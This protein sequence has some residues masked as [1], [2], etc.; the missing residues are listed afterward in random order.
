MGRPGPSFPSLTPSTPPPR[1]PV[2]LP[3]P[4]LG[5]QTPNLPNLSDVII[6]PPTWAPGLPPALPVLSFRP[7]ASSQHPS[8]LSPPGPAQPE[9]ALRP[10]P[11][12]FPD[13]Q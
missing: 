13:P 11:A 2:L 9:V 4:G 12:E 6:S 8:V 3:E 10:L 7:L 1:W 5:E